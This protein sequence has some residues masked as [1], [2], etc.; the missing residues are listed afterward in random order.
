MAVRRTSLNLDFDLVEQ[1]RN[2]LGTKGTTDTVHRALA[3]AVRRQRLRR[4]ARR[5]FTDLEGGR[6]DQLR[7][8]RSARL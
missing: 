6:L 4:L 8:P 3:E 5:E 2:A 7:A 1:A